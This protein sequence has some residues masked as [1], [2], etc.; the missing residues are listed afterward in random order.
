M[1]ICFR[2]GKLLISK[3]NPLF[4]KIIDKSNKYRFNDIYELCSKLIDVV[5]KC[6]MVVVVD[7]QKSLN[8]KV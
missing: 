2:C 3:D 1:C 5:K 8:W 4:K 6:K 7:N